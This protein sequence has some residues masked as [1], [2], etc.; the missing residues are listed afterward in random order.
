MNIVLIFVLYKYDVFDAAFSSIFHHNYQMNF[1][2]RFIFSREIYLYTKHYNRS[3][4]IVYDNTH[5]LA[6]QPFQ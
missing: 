3:H 5:P 6:K 2:Y 1:I 4:S